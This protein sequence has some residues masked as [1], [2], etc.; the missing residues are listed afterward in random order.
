LLRSFV[1]LPQGV[2]FY[3]SPNLPSELTCDPESG[4][5]YG[6]PT[7]AFSGL[8]YLYATNA[9]GTNFT[10]FRLRVVP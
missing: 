9:Q 8:I 1:V 3:T 5:I 7:N 6:T 4:T 10:G 2:G